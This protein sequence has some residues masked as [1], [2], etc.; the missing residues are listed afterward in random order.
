V[1]GWF[2]PAPLP[3]STV[4]SACC[5]P[6]APLPRQPRADPVGRSS[7]SSS[8][9]VVWVVGQASFIA[10]LPVRHNAL[11]RPRYGIGV[12]EL[13]ARRL[14]HEILVSKGGLRNVDDSAGGVRGRARRRDREARVAVGHFS[15]EEFCSPARA[16]MT[17]SSRSRSTSGL[18]RSAKRRRRCR[19]TATRWRATVAQSASVTASSWSPPVNQSCNSP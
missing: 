5:V 10:V 7:S 18:G 17:S 14:N 3:T 4:R 9:E 15:E 8:A 16:G 19:Q 11:G 2:A 1:S 13:R 6:V 12:L